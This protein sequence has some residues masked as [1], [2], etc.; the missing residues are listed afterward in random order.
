M[1]QEYFAPQGARELLAQH[2]LDNFA[3]LW[4]LQL[5]AVDAPNTS[6]GGW[7]SVYRLELTDAEGVA[8]GFYL[9]RQDNHLTR[10]LRHPLGE[11]TFA[12]EFRAI[13]S[14]AGQGIPALKAVYFA[15]R[16]LNGHRQA[17]LLTEALD[18]YEPL[19]TWF[20]S[21]QGLGWRG[22]QRLILAAAKLIRSLHQ[23]GK[24]HQCLYPK[25]VF[26]KVDDQGADARLIDLE[27]TRRAWFGQADYVADLGSFSRRSGAPSR[28]ERLRFILA[29]LQK[30][31]LDN[32]AKAF[33]IR[34]QKRI[35]AKERR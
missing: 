11:P 5:D 3:A 9:K 28:T 35:E 12:R 33:I 18:G 32:E 10:S 19:S 1:I 21:W 7:S 20:Q 6:R 14:Y 22:K 15:Q 31:H 17:L 2:G 26:L 30:S 24:V 23:A 34:I 8:R 27:K 16:R 25:H 4:A 13:K 29:Y